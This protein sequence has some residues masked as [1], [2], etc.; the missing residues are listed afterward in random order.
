MDAEPA[1][2]AEN[3]RSTTKKWKRKGKGGGEKKTFFTFSDVLHL[4]SVWKNDTRPLVVGAA[5]VAL[6]TA[7]RR[8]DRGL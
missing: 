1:R 8:T 5:L 7:V 6:W 3:C 2:I 4:D